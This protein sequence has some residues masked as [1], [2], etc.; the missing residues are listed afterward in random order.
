MLVSVVLPTYKERENIGPLITEILRRFENLHHKLQIIVVD[1][2][3]PDGTANEVSKAIQQSSYPGRSNIHLLT[4]KKQ[5]LGAAYI[6][7]FNFAL[8]KFNPDFEKIE[9]LKNNY[10]S[11]LY[12]FLS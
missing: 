4:G 9:Q 12:L 11:S 8:K 3:S 5:G 1:D 10:T 6:R 7:G 2:K